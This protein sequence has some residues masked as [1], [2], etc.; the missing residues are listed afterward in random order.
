MVI[1]I[2]FSIIIRGGERNEIYFTNFEKLVLYVKN[3]IKRDSYI[4]QVGIRN[5]RH[6]G[7]VFNIRVIMVYDGASWQWVHEVR[8]ASHYS[9]IST[10]PF[11]G[12]SLDLFQFMSKFLGKLELE[13][14]VLK[15]KVM[16]FGLTEYLDNTYAGKV[17]E[18]AYD[19][20]VDHEYDIY[21]VEINTK[22]GT[23]G[24]PNTLVNFFERE[25]YGEQTDLYVKYMAKFFKKKLESLGFENGKPSLPE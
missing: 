9:A 15:L 24:D 20:V 12:T 19:F 22:P 11:L 7:S 8:C 1:H 13:V 5:L 18:V 16:A 6:M 10:F 14:F 3:I 2:I 25:T 21:L 17:F 23:I 4:I